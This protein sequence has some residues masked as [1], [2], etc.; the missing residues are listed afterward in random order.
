MAAFYRC[1]LDVGEAPVVALNHAQQR[2]R[3]ATAEDLTGLLP[4][5]T[6]SD[7]LYADPRH[8]AAFAYTGV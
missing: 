7:R 4:G 6:P 1:W 2:L 3:S 5:L 8:W